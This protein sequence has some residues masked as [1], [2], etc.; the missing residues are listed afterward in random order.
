MKK[1]DC[2]CSGRVTTLRN[3]V[4]IATGKVSIRGEHEHRDEVHALLERAGARVTTKM[5]GN[6]SVLIHG[7]LSGQ[8]V[9]D[10]VREYSQKILDLLT[11]S[12]SAHHV[13]AVSSRGLSELLEGRA[14]V[15]LHRHVV[16]Q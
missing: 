4:V 3:Q 13:C 9:A 7:D 6:I 8:I 11:E 5:S 12:T 1:N 14:A 10:Q 15:C 2:T 16:G